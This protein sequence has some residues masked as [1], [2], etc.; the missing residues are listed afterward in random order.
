MLKPDFIFFGEGIPQV[1]YQASVDAAQHSDLFILIG[2]S[3]Q[4]APANQ[5]PFLAK[6]YGAQ[7]IEINMEP[8]SYTHRITDIYLE[9]SASKIMEKLAEI[10][11]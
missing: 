10:V 11:F 5:M 3:G 9:G 6:Q 8:S 1:A 4:V 2:T 7:I